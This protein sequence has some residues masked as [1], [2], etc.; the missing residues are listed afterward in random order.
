MRV[1]RIWKKL[2][3]EQAVPEPDGI[4]EEVSPDGNRPEAPV[5]ADEALADPLV[6]ESEQLVHDQLTGDRVEGSMNVGRYLF[7]Q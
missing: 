6:H 3:R 5:A 1:C 2:F 4:P 7:Q